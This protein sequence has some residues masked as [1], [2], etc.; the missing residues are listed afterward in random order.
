MNEQPEWGGQGMPKSVSNA[1]SEYFNG[2]TPL[3]MY[4]ALTHGAGKLVEESG[5][6]S[7][8]NLS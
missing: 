6:L 4:P 1:L 7:R 5:P 3:A 8:K 2:Q